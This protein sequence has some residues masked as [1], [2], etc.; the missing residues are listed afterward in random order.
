MDLDELQ[1]RW[2]AQ[3][4]KLDEAL[5][6]SQ[7]ALRTTELVRTRSAMQRLSAAI[8]LESAVSTVAVVVLGS[9]IADN[10][11]ELRFVFAALSLLGVALGVLVWTLRQAIQAGAIDYDAPVVTLQHHL[12]ALRASRIRS[13][14]VVLLISP[15]LW[16]PLLIV[17]LRAAFGVDAYA[18]PGGTYLLVNL[19]C[20]LAFIGAMFWFCRRF[21]DRLGRSPLVQRL[22]RDVAGR[23]L[24]AALDQLARIA[25]FEREEGSA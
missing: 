14:Q 16:T 25:A 5:R 20:G 17:G 15:L 12:Q 2:V 19:L 9:F 6:L 22:A 11:A 23:N 7:R 4:R 18:T 3:D 21:A 13:T 1:Q 24:S 8:G 10:I